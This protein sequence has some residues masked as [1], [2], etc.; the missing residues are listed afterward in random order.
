M[1]SDEMNAEGVGVGR[2]E[3]SGRR[4]EMEMTERIP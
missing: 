3:E 1:R 4:M 2:G